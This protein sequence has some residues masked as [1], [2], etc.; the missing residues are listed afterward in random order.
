MTEG[1]NTEVDKTVI[2]KLAEP[3]TRLRSAMPSTTASK[4]RKSAPPPARIFE[5][6]IKLTAS[7]VRRILIELQ[8]DGAGINR[9]R[10]KQKAI[11]KT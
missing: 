10:V 8:D 5:G 2:D 1:E 6:T 7:I 4:A 9:E 11:D 3:L